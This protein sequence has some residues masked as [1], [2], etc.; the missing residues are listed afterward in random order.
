[1]GAQCESQYC[2]DNTASRP[3]GHSETRRLKRPK[4]QRTIRHT[5]QPSPSRAASKQTTITYEVQHPQDPQRTVKYQVTQSREK[6]RNKAAVKARRLSQGAFCG[7]KPATPT[8]K[9][10]IEAKFQAAA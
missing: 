3:A 5:A 8:T 6:D 7:L 2:Q 9:D 4:G 1:M 10:E